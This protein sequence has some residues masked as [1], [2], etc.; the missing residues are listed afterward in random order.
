MVDRSQT[1]D[2]PLEYAS[3]EGIIP[4]G[5]YGAGTVLIWDQGSWEPL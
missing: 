1:E 5:N 3:F 4:A 2:H